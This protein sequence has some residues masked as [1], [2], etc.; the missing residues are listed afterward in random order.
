M[1]RTNNPHRERL[2]SGLAVG[3]VVGL[4]AAIA[5]LL[6]PEWL[7]RGESWTYDQRARA[8]AR[9]AEA[10]SAVVLLGISEEDIEDV[11]NVYGVSWPWPRELYGYLAQFARRAGAR[12]IVY[13]WLFQDRAGGVADAET[14]AAAMREAGNAVIGLALTSG[15]LVRRP[16][17]GPWAARLPAPAPTRAEA[18]AIAMALAAW[19]TRTFPEPV[20]AD[21][22]GPVW[23]WYGGKR[24]EADVR[25]AHQRLSAVDEL[26]PYFVDPV[27]PPD[28][29]TGEAPVA[30][31]APVQ[32]PEATLAR[33]VTIQRVIAE[34]DGL[35]IPDGGLALPVRRGLD[36]PLAPIAYAAARGGSVYQDPEA[37]GVMRR[38]TPLVRHGDRLYPSLALA[39]YLVAH[40]EVTPSL[41][42]GAL[43]LGDRRVPL[44]GQGKVGIR[45]HGRG[46][47]PRVGAFEA[48]RSLALL[49][50]KEAALR[51]EL[52]AAGVPEEEA[53]ARAR[54]RADAEA[55]LPVPLAALAGRYVVVAA[56][57]QAL[58]DIRVTPVSSAMEGAEIQATAL[59]NLEQ[60]RFVVRTSPWLDAALALLLCLVTAVSVVFLW[61]AIPRASL[62]LA[63]TLGTTAVLLAGCWLVAGRLF[64]GSGTWLA[65][66]A[67]ASGISL[68]AFL[69]LLVTSAAERRGRRFVQEALGRYTSPE[70]VRE[71]VAHPEYLSLEWGEKRPMSV[72]FSDIAGFTTISE[73]LPPERLVALL[74]DYLTHMTDIVL[75]HGG[76]VDKY[77]GDAVMAFWGAPLPD[78]QH[79]TRAVR[80]ALAMRRR[81]DELR[82]VWLR[83]Y[84][85]EVR[86][87]AGV[88]S[89]HAV[90]GNM[91]SKHKYNYTAMGDMVNL[92]SRLEGANKPYG[93]YL[94]ISE[95]TL[96][97]IGD[98]VD[99][100]ELD[101]L[102]VK[103]KEQPVRVYEVLDE[104][105]RTD[106][107]TQAAV[108]RYLAGLARYRARDFVGAITAF[109]A[110]LAEKPDDR[111][112]MMYIDRCRHFADHPPADDWDG[113][114]R[115]EEK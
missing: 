42:G 12:V 67:P 47:Y 76:V 92:A 60:G 5:A 46:V 74:N 16:L 62:A 52:V 108:A 99:V 94:M 69:A 33:E 29:A 41:A 2:L 85:T 65:V 83:D 93:T 91:G 9:P 59:D 114:W 97:E 7:E 95:F 39:A 43:R 79:A 40:P 23:L 38:H 61:G 26:R 30:E 10:S 101:L 115:L 77:I 103:G 37:D 68:S 106:A 107:A 113:V 86:A 15:E 6:R 24:S 56:S 51:D 25:M 90:V 14:F 3:L 80:C 82:P 78:A 22:D 19:N 66:A 73:G 57:A 70:L 28:E 1:K 72:Y 58:R 89:G 48:L 27:A 11:E 8:A 17:E 36:P 105:G 102:A 81:C 54:R 100:R 21:P 63:A 32:L 18:Q 13:D 4:L 104:K 44:D 55:E 75:Q 31:P 34:R 112:S 84:G 20:G 111:P 35:A 96:A 71:L 109:E 98:L 87:R 53:A 49:E 50:E 45:Y 88:N 110:A 64:D